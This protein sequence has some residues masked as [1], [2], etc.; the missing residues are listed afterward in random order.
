MLI[1]GGEGTGRDGTG[2]EGEWEEENYPM[3]IR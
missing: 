3:P 1:G 2:G